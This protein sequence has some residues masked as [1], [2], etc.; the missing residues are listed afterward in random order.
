MF[1]YAGRQVLVVGGGRGIGRGIALAY[2]RAG[3][4][5]AVAARSLEQLAG[6]VQE[7]QAL[8]RDAWALP[9]DL[10]APRA[11]DDLVARALG[12][13][14]RIDV[15]VNSAG[16]TGRLERDTFELTEADFEHVSALHVRSALFTSIRA[17]ESMVR[18]GLPGA[19][20]NITSV[21]GQFVSP[22]AV[23]YGAMKAAVN[24]FTATLAMEFG[25]HGI[26]VNA[27]APGPI[28][29][30][31]IADRLTTDEDRAAMASFY[32]LNRVGEVDDVAA[33]ALYLCSAEASWVSGETLVINGGQQATSGMFRWPR[34]HNEVPP[35]R[36]I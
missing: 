15:L 7:I 26:R 35:A 5:V 2:A 22:G 20:L 4:D 31:L 28:D 1:S 11:A 24:H 12:V 16:D 29:T 10:T 8:G 6:V 21:G 36:R 19:I 3:A 30:P 13:L 14:G 33:A 32:P 34:I 25:T 17:A 23:L 18:L 27:I 9:V